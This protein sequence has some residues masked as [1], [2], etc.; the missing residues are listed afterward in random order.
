VGLFEPFADTAT[1]WQIPKLLPAREP[2]CL[3]KII[4]NHTSLADF[5]IHPRPGARRACPPRRRT[6]ATAGSG[7]MPPAPGS[8]TEARSEAMRGTTCSAAGNI[9]AICR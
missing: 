4:A 7:R 1:S 3:R 6:I 9:G 5:L 2:H 8:S